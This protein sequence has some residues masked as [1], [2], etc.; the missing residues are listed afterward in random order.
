MLYEEF[1]KN[2]KLPKMYMVKQHFERPQIFDVRK[3]VLDKIS[4]E[5]I[6][7]LISE[8]DSDCITAGSRGIH[9]MPTVLK[10]V[11]DFCKEKQAKPF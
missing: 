7:S 8:G 5:K 11:V 10:A 3:E 9:S 1:C 6:A 4:C 2:V